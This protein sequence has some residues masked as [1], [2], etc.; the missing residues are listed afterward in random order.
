MLDY[1]KTVLEKVSFD[2]SLFEKELT[3]SINWLDDS[4]KEEFLKWSSR[5]FKIPP[6][7]FVRKKLM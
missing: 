6:E 1:C 3:K 7:Y 2:P 4:E 5:T